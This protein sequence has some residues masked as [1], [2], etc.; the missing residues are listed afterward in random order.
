VDQV[1]GAAPSTR[2]H[3]LLMARRFLAACWGTG[4]LDWSS[5]QAQQLADCVPHEAANQ[6]GGGRTLPRPA[7]RSRLRLLVCRG[8]RAPGLEAAALAPRQW[9]HDAIP[10]RLPAQEVERSLALST[11]AMPVNVRHRASLML[12][13][14]L[15]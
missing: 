15:G 14:R 10:H 5:W 9:P 13:A 11:G 2:G 8:A 4:H 3:S 7:V 1:C 6:H 12:L